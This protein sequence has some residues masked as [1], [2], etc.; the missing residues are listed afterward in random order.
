MVHAGSGFEE[1]G[2]MG[3][4]GWPKRVKHE[5]PRAFVVKSFQESTA[6][7]LGEHIPLA[8]WTLNST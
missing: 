5:I 4:G 2:L 6:L 1:G 3:T 8:L 7:A